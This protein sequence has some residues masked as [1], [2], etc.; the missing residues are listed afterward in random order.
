MTVEG[1]DSLSRIAGLV[2]AVL[3]G[4]A[5]VVLGA[6]AV[7]AVYRGDGLLAVVFGIG[8]L[9]FAIDIWRRWRTSRA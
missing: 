2:M 5:F 7:Y 1:Q 4:I 3:E 9:T 6:F 8:S